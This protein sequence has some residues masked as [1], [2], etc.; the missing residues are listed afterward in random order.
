MRFIS[1]VPVMA[2]VLAAVCLMPRAAAGASA[3]TDA[4]K[5][6]Q[7]VDA[8]VHGKGYL[9]WMERGLSEKEIAFRKE[10]E[11]RK[12]RLLAE[13]APIRHPVM[14][15]ARALETARKNVAEAQWARDIVKSA[16]ERADYILGK[17]DGY[18]DDMIGE[19]TPW[20]DYGMTCPNCVGVKSQEGVGHGLMQWSY[21][22]PDKLTCRL[23]GQVYPSAKYAETQ[24]LVCPRTGQTFMFYLNEA[25][26][27]HPGDRTGKY[28]FKWFTYPFHM[29]FSGNI[30]KSKTTFMISSLNDLALTYSITG[31]P[32]YA[33]K[34]QQILLRLAKC[35]RGWLYHDYRNTV[36][37]ADPLYAAWHDKELELE[38]K[39]NLAT[40]A[41]KRDGLHNAFVFN[42]WG[43]GREHP[44]TD[45]MGIL[46]GLARA[47]DFVA[48]ATDENGNPLW[49]EADKAKVERDLFLEWIFTGEPYLGGPDQ[50]KLINNKS[51]RL[52]NAYAAVARALNLPRLADTAM[53]GYEAVRERSFNFDGFSVES[54]GYTMMYLEELPMVPELLDNFDWPDS[55]AARRAAGSVYNDPRLRNMYRAMIDTLR[56]D[57]A[58]IPFEDSDAGGRIPDE[59]IQ[60]GLRH[61]PEFFAGKAGVLGGRSRLGTYALFNL[62]GEEYGGTTRTLDLK[63]LYFP[64]WMT[65]LLRHGSDRDAALLG[66]NFS[67]PGSHRHGDN[68]T[69]YYQ[70]HGGVML[71]DHG[72]VGDSPVNQWITSTF[73]H[74]LVIVNDRN[75][76]AHGRDDTIRKPKL[77]MMIST[78]KLSAC[79][80]SSNANPPCSDY[81]RLVVLLKGPD[82]ATFAVDIFRVRGGSKHDFRLFSELASSDAGTSGALVFDGVAMP[83]E[84]PLPDFGASLEREHIWGLRDT[85]E[86][87]NPP[88]EFQATWTDTGRSYR[89]WCLGQVGK[90]QASNGPGQESHAMPGRRVRVL[91]LV[92]EVTTGTASTFVGVHEPSLVGGSMP[93][94]SA[95]QIKVPAS[96]GPNAVAV[97]IE[98]AWGSYLVLSEFDKE[99]KVG[100]VR[101][102]G[103]FGVFGEE[104]GAG[105][106]AGHGKPWYVASGARTLKKGLFGLGFA[107]KPAQWSGEA[108]A[109]TA[110]TLTAGGRP[111]GWI[112]PPAGCRSYVLLN[113]PLAIGGPLDTGLPVAST[114]AGSI[115]VDRFPIPEGAGNKFTLP[116]LRYME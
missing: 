79:E 28:S 3:L 85:R 105:A 24:K 29:S 65:G 72:Y 74:N 111:K 46:M 57:G 89:F 31:D 80:A 68:L 81:R 94:K 116:A 32:R 93:V 103:K 21:K 16:R 13:R 98:T 92:D 33:R 2:L 50:A 9:P 20:Y 15:D 6:A 88:A 101:F 75:Q 34:A 97:R 107:G 67:P 58:I 102:Q 110:D 8:V 47:F 37:D 7:Y 43:A 83:P 26:K 40:D 63:D 35:Y 82:G 30:A 84:P 62:S 14:I 49:S 45:N 108:S 42:F 64:A 12:T 70:D 44:S 22:D 106:P 112:D 27:A 113:I 114:T 96:A 1:R 59:C 71:G 10:M 11:E 78:P 87:V 95:K 36:I 19:L 17:P 41:Y 51:P 56:P 39:R 54:P 109:K 61:Y 60:I 66:L 104:C 18:V 99:A 100:G 77:E 86:A 90:V 5:K 53:R 91:D 25:E 69:V 115:K 4:E 48:D 76:V 52:Y 23:C 73:S 55:F 38:W